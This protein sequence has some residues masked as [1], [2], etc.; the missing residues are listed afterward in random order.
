L[1]RVQAVATVEKPSMAPEFIKAP[2]EGVGIYQ[3]TDGF[4]YCDALKVDDIRAQVAA[5]IFY[6]YSWQQIR[7]A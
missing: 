5:S 7:C 1:L 6:L 3:G 4:L 2:E